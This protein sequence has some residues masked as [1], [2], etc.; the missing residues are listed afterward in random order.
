VSFLG[1]LL[2]RIVIPAAL[3]AWSVGVRA[4]GAPALLEGKHGAFF[5]GNDAYYHA[6]RIWY[7]VVNFPDFLSRDAYSNFPHGAQPIWSPAFDWLAAVVVRLAAGS[8]DQPAM[9][10]LLVWIPPVLG[11]LTVVVLYLLALR[12]FSRRVA[13]AAGLLLSIMPGHFWYSQFGFVDH[14]VAVALVAICLAAAT[15]S[16]FARDTGAERLARDAWLAALGLGLLSGFALLIWPGCLIHVAIVDLALVVH[17]LASHNS[18]EAMARARLYGLASVV[19]LALIFP[20]SWGNEWDRWGSLSPLVLSHF[21]P[22]WFAAA[23]ICFLSLGELWG[24]RGLPESKLERVLHTALV[25]GA[26]AGLFLTLLPVLSGG[27]EESWAWFAKGESFQAS[28]GESKAL[29]ADGLRRPQELFTRALFLAPVLLIALVVYAWRRPREERDGLLFFVAWCLALGAA[30]VMQRRFMNSYSVAWSLLLGWGICAGLSMCRN[31]LRRRAGGDGFGWV[32][33]ATLVLGVIVLFPVAWSYKPYVGNLIQVM[34]G[35]PSLT[36]FKL[37]R[38]I[39]VREGLATWLRSN[40]PP[41]AGWL[42]ASQ[43]PQYSLLAPWSGGHVMKY[44]AHRPVIWDNFGDDVGRENFAAGEGYYRSLSEDEALEHL[45]GLGVRYVVARED[46][47]QRSGPRNRRNMMSRLSRFTGSEAILGGR[48]DDEE[49]Q[50]HLKALK[51]HRLIYSSVPL[52][53]E[54]G[55]GEPLFKVFELVRGARVV[56]KGPPGERVM[57]RL[58]LKPAL[59]AKF[60]YVATADVDEAGRYE[61]VLPYPTEPFS[62][63]VEPLDKAYQIGIGKAKSQLRVPEIAVRQGRKVKGPNFQKR[64]QP[65]GQRNPTRERLERSRKKRARE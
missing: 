28:V 63:G 62:T 14:H 34:N 16:L 12:F 37:Q 54:L 64:E 23:T 6:R 17:L 39:V 32:V 52:V 3:F 13:F 22:L 30:T 43:T 53:A 55:R 44:V 46:H 33:F 45:E 21:Q 59:D 1:G 10:R 20:W 7:T 61:L 11:G 51:R 56:G 58:P 38:R 47:D 26:V 29:F 18:R 2:A 49:S 65:E 41:T 9:E 4:V 57:A 8:A 35:Q 5:F 31:I 36:I 60:F 15:M 25:G 19:A 40:T 48:E 24:R 42:D 27:L 50:I